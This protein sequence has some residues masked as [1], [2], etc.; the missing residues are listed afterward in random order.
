MGSP[1][2]QE[3]IAVVG[4]GCRFPEAEDVHAFWSNIEA[5]RTAFSDVPRD[6][7][8]HEFF[9]SATQRD[10]DKTWAPR[11]SFIRRYREF[12][13]LHYG[14]APRRLEVMDPQQRLL[15][16]ATRW[17][18]QDAGFE[19][20][21]FD[22]R[23]TG[24]FT[25]VS[26]SEFKNITQARMHAMQMA[27]GDYGTAAG[28]DLREQFMALTGRIVPMRA[29]TLSGSLTA[30]N[31]A[32]V[33]QVF[34]MGGP[35]YTID[36]AC[37]SASVA[38]HNAVMM[39]RAGALDSAVA[40]GAYV[41]L[42]PDNLIAFTKI[43]AISP[44]GA[45]RPFDERA[46]GFV[47]S[48]G[49][50]MVVLKRLSDAQ[51]DGDRIHAVIIGSGCNNDGRGEGPM[52]PRREGQL[53]VL[54]AAYEDAGVSP[55]SVGFF[56]AHGTATSIGDPVEVQA[57]GTFLRESGS[58][59]EAFLG[60]VKGN[61]GH[62]MSA[63]GIAG[64]IKAIN[65][66]RSGQVPPQPNFHK[67]HPKL[68]LDEQPL[69]VPTEL[70]PLSERDGTHRVAV[71]S[72][73]FGG[74]NS[75]LVLEAPPVRPEAPERPYELPSGE[76]EAVLVTGAS[77]ALLGSHCGALA[78]FLETGPGKNYS[79]A[80]VAFTL[81]AR[82][83]R[84]RVRAV[85]G[86]RSRYELV[87]QLRELQTQLQQEP[88][89]PLKLSPHVMV[90]DRD[91]RITKAPK[92]AFLFPGQGA[93]KVGAL[94]DLRHRFPAYADS[95]RQLSDAVRAQVPEGLEHYLYPERGDEK[96]QLQ[97]L[98]RTEICQPALA[99]ASLSLRTL[100]DRV[101]VRSEVSLGHSLGEFCAL[102][103]AGAATPQDVLRLVAERG[104]TMARLRLADAGA[105][106][107]VMAEASVVR[108]RIQ[109]ID[110]VVVANV[111]H[112]RQC[113]LSGTTPGVGAASK[114]LE[115]Q[116]L[117]VRPLSVS[118]AFH[119]PLMD[120][121]A[122]GLRPILE[123]L[124]FQAP[125][126]TVASCI[127]PRPYDEDLASLRG[128]LVEHATSPVLF[129]RGL[130][131]ARE[132]GSEVFV[133]LGAGATLLGFA[134][135]TLGRDLPTVV[136]ADDAADGGYSFVR[137]LCQLAALGVPVA[138]DAVYA[139]EG[140]QV[141]S[142][143][144]TPLVREEYWPV[145]NRPQPQ[146]KFTAPEPRDSEVTVVHAPAG[147]GPT[148]SPVAS[149]VA[150]TPASNDMVALFREQMALLQR[151]TEVLAAQAQALS[152][153]APSLDAPAPAQPHTFEQ[154]PAPIRTP[155]VPQ[156][157]Q[158]TAPSS[159]PTLAESSVPPAPV[160]AS[161]TVEASTSAAPVSKKGKDA[162]EVR[163]KVFELV[164]RVSAFPEDS[165]RPE[166][167]LV[168]ELGFDSLMVAD[169]GGAIDRAFPGSGGL[170]QDLFSLST[171]VEDVAKH[172]VAVV[173]AGTLTDSEATGASEFATPEP[174]Q[175]YEV[176]TSVRPLSGRP[177][178]VNGQIWLVTEDDGEL[179]EQISTGLARAGA[180]VVR[181]RFTRQGVAAP[182]RLSTRGV[183]FW[184]AEYA[185]GL[186][187]A[188]RSSSLE[189]QGMVHA[190]GL[191][192]TDDLN[193]PLELLHP[194]VSRLRP[195]R[196]MV[197]TDLGGRLGLE[198]SPRMEGRRVQAT[199]QGY[200]KAV[201]RERSDD[202]IKTIDVDGGAPASQLAS[203]VLAEIL[204]AKGDVEVGFADGVRHVPALYPTHL[205][206]GRRPLGADDVVL[207]TGGT[208]AIGA[209]I[210]LALA[211]QKP[212]AIILSGRR[213]VDDEIRSLIARIE[214]TGCAAAYAAV[215]VRKAEA[216][217]S[218]VAEAGAAHGLPTV[219]IHAAG[220]IADAPANKKSMD[221]VLSVLGTKLAGLEALANAF[222][223][224]RDL[225]LFSSWAGRFGNASQSDY[226]A[227]NQALDVAAVAG[228]GAPRVLS[229]AWPPWRGTAMVDT[230]PESLQAVMEK[231]GV[232]FLAPEEGVEA[233][234]RL[235]E[236]GASG[237]R[238]VGRQLPVAELSVSEDTR[239]DVERYGY[240]A[241]HAL[242]GRPVV[243]M[244]VVLDWVARVLRRVV[245][246]D[247][248]VTLESF[249]LVRGVMGG[250]TARLEID[251]R[252]TE[253]GLEGQVVIKVEGQVAYRARL[254]TPA[255]AEWTE[256]E[257]NGA[258]ASLS[259]DDFYRDFTFHG[260]LLKGIR[261]IDGIG[262]GGI[263]GRVQGV[264]SREWGVDEAWALDPL[265]L[266]SAF[267]L[268]GYWTSMKLGRTGFPTGV[269]H[270]TIMPWPS[271]TPELQAGLRFGSREGDGFEGDL[272][273]RDAEGRVVVQMRGL[274]G[275]FADVRAVGEA[276][277]PR[278]G[279][280]GHTNGRTNGK[281]N[282]NGH[283][284]G[285]APA[286]DVPDAHWKVA[287]FPEL[288]ALEQRFAMAEQVGVRNPYFRV[289]E[290]TARDTSVVEGVSMVNYSSYNYLG[291]SGHP[292]VVAA[293][294][295]SIQ[296]YGTSV[297]ASRVASG[298]RPLHR[299]LEQGLARHVGVEDAIVMVSGHATNVTTVGHVMGREDLV[300]HDSLIHDSIL[301]GIYLSGATRRPF[302][303]NDFDAAERTLAQV[304]KNFRR[305]LLVAE[306]IY[307]M[308]GDTTDLPRLI[309]LKQR[310]K[311]LLMIDEAHSIGVL[312][313][314]GRGI[315]HHFPDVDP[316]D[317]D[318][319]MGTLSKSFASCGGYIAGSKE[320]V[321][322]L[323]YTAPGFVYS[324][325]LPAPNAAAALKSL[326]L[327]N[328]HP[329]IVEQL[330][331][332][333][334]FFVK[335]LRERGID[336]GD[337]IG[338]A[339]VPA[340]I[341]N[342]VHALKLSEALGGRR[343]NVQPIVYP[344]VEENASRLRFF[345]SATHTE[346]QLRQT[347]DAIV[348][349]L[350]RIRGGESASSVSL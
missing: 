107:A 332:R 336:T 2:A 17:A 238:V 224:L 116:E 156:T 300:L 70:S 348:E 26:V 67:P 95:F 288:G 27:A 153:V 57:L 215:D 297:S 18:I 178:D 56:E 222:P 252:R 253:A 41:N 10:V 151:Q 7:W 123:E 263:K 257:T 89:L 176:R 294:Q 244:A 58:Q 226:A 103:D 99:A 328:R 88:E 163:R 234:L 158:A 295:A 199:L 302:P 315:A 6:R 216:L 144:E 281:G 35:A 190:A 296:T 193:R 258:T 109:D 293:A 318:I 282:G 102:A 23:R 307:S 192:P 313:P 168:D 66:L 324:A 105:M 343:I 84:E 180:Q 148:P 39:L 64:F 104:A 183:N 146:T 325:G 111:N 19:G 259:L 169:L 256:V 29:F 227:A 49:V 171:T 54:R 322:Y 225:I 191:S 63:A 329:E 339:V 211:E 195:G 179:S 133:Q 47:Q 205:Q 154:E 141:V 251:G 128:S 283:S 170:P 157:V 78:D 134:R 347:A 4:I 165:L 330:R 115:E 277:T 71:S 152:G 265:A 160:E 114:R 8:H 218:A 308:D 291:F 77:V 155:E 37:A 271:P 230:I 284:H 306:G 202:V 139:G 229:I 219:A 210:A 198:P 255:K 117:D 79:L 87:R 326:E 14:L 349:E 314:A 51:A 246:P 24:V 320:L 50:G 240:L 304:R 346:A 214:A 93:Q 129:A 188:L 113:V 76:P 217:R 270:V 112:P 290:G 237:L 161:P 53:E 86:A 197:L 185:D 200:T 132:A 241:D 340:I 122:K 145:K 61:I 97:A 28:E 45:C 267:Q 118:H 321:Q 82:R 261:S 280:A 286:L 182:S 207:I 90:V 220:F 275:R 85:I 311:T 262:S 143:P 72:F 242:K 3:P 33:A 209:R 91:P 248:P 124:A 196:L 150:P 278:N 235:F 92:L 239:F 25:G 138:F 166:Q 30:L 68:N 245:G 9:Y 285:A 140:R 264:E 38:I 350:T 100:L 232:P 20:V 203:L 312:G 303:H 149:P 268:G 42:S 309:E 11:G 136:L 254:G 231:S 108:D 40:G 341:G 344:A 83:H 94:E 305:V 106:A 142:L 32:A 316:N 194:L 274:K 289:H 181:V 110:G 338:A 233:F 243:P 16:E 221:G 310:Y 273:L 247:A 44:T 319:W 80:D 65:V 69:R 137:G 1:K 15:I 43:G 335:L 206:E 131:Q 75:H 127:R 74:T 276:A 292:E 342:S 345:I 46:D 73:G 55:A 189:P 125:R 162:E 213:A 212:K 201:A 269:D 173:T 48:D 172:L 334:R 62:A 130:E 12:A 177:T 59:A 187:E 36:S 184:P 299:E 167:R 175:S 34:D 204:G 121:V 250:D 96:A 323:K 228:F 13:A 31:A 208:G 260:P 120:G 21:G 159:E 174:A 337:A 327:M 298:E 301:Q 60:S 98:T 135:A 272:G 147:G 22:R 331:A 223:Q 279:A 81:N 186:P 249:E 333:S 266:D 52:T 119:S 5:G 101:G 287:A 236:S 164:S 317:V 126:K